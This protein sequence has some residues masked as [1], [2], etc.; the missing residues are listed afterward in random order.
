MGVVNANVVISNPADRRQSWKG[1]FLV[2][3]GATDSLVPRQHL[4]A[5]GLKPEAQRTY[6]LAD[7]SDVR[8]DVA[9]ARFELLGEIVGGTVLFG[10]PDAEPL[11][12]VTALES[13][14]IEV[15]PLNQQ[16][17]KL[18]AVRLKKASERPGGSH[19]KEAPHS[20]SGRQTGR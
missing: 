4:E 13:L 9:V 6:I 19:R 7:G 2:D 1:R 14:G 8:L 3:T 17:K 11:L 18:P 15:D 16:L 20:V 5:I 12:G 10:A